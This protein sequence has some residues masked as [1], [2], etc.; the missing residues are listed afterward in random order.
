MK[1]YADEHVDG[2]IARELEEKMEAVLELTA[3]ESEGTLDLYRALAVLFVAHTPY[4]WLVSPSPA[5][6]AEWLRA[7][8]DLLAA[9]RGPTA[10]RLL[11]F[12]PKGR[13]L[14]LTNTSDAPFLVDSLQSLLS[15][16]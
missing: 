2:T 3:A 16:L 11:P 5:Q 13:A 8:L 4:S 7:F 10:V 14:L 12:G 6:L 15:S 9:R 1:I